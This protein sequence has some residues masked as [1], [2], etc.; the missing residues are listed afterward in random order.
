MNTELIEKVRAY[1]KKLM[2]SS[3]CVELQ[4]HNWEHTEDVVRNAKFIASHEQL[5]DDTIEEI[6]IASYFHDTGNVK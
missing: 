5:A 1:C 2:E 3:R 6:I 4:F